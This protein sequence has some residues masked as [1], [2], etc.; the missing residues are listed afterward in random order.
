MFSNREIQQLRFP[1]MKRDPWKH[2]GL[3]HEQERSVTGDLEQT[4]TVFLVGRE[5]PFH[6][7]MCDLWQYTLDQ[8]TP[9][10]AI[11]FQLRQAIDQIP[12]R[13]TIKLYNASNFF[14][15]RSVPESDHESVLEL[16]RPFQ[17]VIVENHPR[18]TTPVIQEFA[19]R[20]DGRLEVAMGLETSNPRILATL[21][22]QMTIEDFSRS[23][24]MLKDWDVDVRAF[25]I[26][27]LPGVTPDAARDDLIASL[28]F[29][30]ECGVDLCTAI[31]L[32]G[33]NGS[34][35]ELIRRGQ[36]QVPLLWDFVRAVDAGLEVAQSANRM[37]LADLWDLETLTTCPACAGEAT[38]WLRQA[39]GPTV[40]DG[41]RFE[42][43]HNVT[44]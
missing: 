40:P 12:H 30:Y 24:Q 31:P 13:Q 19:R 36:A 42:C 16:L 7:L 26:Y 37:L 33:G 4:S 39:N 6:C 22:K 35:D 34:I 18:L 21:N 23:V 32:R 5:C 38:H 1:K 11:A 25:V 10:G 27:Q 15:P 43:R 44:H 20:L 9:N 29:A 28:H 3:T 8:P 14:D 2:L 41:I 17:R